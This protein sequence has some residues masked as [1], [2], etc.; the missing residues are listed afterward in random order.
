MAQYELDVVF[1]RSEERLTVSVRVADE[2]PSAAV[3]VGEEV[4]KDI[5]W[6]FSFWKRGETHAVHV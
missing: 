4:S 2:R 6:C 3:E 5:C 1:Y